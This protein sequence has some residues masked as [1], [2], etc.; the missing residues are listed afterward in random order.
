MWPLNR[1]VKLA[2]KVTDLYVCRGLK[3]IAPSSIASGNGVSLL[4]NRKG[5]VQR[6][7]P[8]LTS[9]LLP[10]GGLW[11]AVREENIVEP[12]DRGYQMVVHRRF[13]FAE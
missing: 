4:D 12:R 13:A 8:F 10:T 11:V 2:G 5:L 7:W 6:N 9:K 1:G 3:V